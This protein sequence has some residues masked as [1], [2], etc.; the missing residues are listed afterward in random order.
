V[1]DAGGRHI[2]K[3]DG[4]RKSI[5]CGCGC[6]SVFPFIDTGDGVSIVV[7]VLEFKEF[8]RL[9]FG[10]TEDLVKGDNSVLDVI[11]IEKI[12]SCFEKTSQ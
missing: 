10:L 7:I 6:I 11:V 9:C 1:V 5:G 8:H 2:G 3:G 4:I 12:R